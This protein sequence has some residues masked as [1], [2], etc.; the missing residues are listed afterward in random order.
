MDKR[1]V[2][3]SRAAADSLKL[4]TP[5]QKQE[6]IKILLKIQMKPNSDYQLL[7]TAY[8]VYRRI[9]LANG[10]ITVHYRK[11]KKRVDAIS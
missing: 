9:K 10:T 4:L 3:I 2:T 11:Q 8:G 5:A 7:G 6:F 1:T